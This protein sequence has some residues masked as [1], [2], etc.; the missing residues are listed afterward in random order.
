MKSKDDLLESI[1]KKKPRGLDKNNNPYKIL[2][3][4]DSS[5]MRRIIIQML[6]SEMYDVCGEAPNGREAL[7]VYKETEPDLVTLDVNMPE[8]SGIE[9]LKNILEYDGSAKIVMLT[10]EGEKESVINLM[11]IGA[12][13]YIVKPPD[14]KSMLDKIEN[15]LK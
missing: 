5:T 10:S 15:V 1:N 3:V 14:R 13:N 7:E 11:K 12:K 6:K 4:D 8:V 9:A 2:V